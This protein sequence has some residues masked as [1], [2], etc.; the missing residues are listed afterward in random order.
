MSNPQIAMGQG[1]S[2]SAARGLSHYGPPGQS[3]NPHQ[4]I[5]QYQSPN[6]GLPG[7][8]PPRNNGVAGSPGYHYGPPPGGPR[9]GYGR[10]GG[11][12]RGMAPPP[13]SSGGG[14][15]GGGGKWHHN[16]RGR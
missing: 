14:R 1:L 11:R 8:P 7:P 10:V 12:G 3:Y 9:S 5:P 4:P 15:G 13:P 6:N 16:G 2:P